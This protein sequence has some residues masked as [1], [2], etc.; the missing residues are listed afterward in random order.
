MYFHIVVGTGSYT[1]STTNTYNKDQFHVQ[2][3]VAV[4]QWLGKAER[5]RGY[6]SRGISILPC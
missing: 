6:Q 3:P 5:S 2:M 4:R 1:T